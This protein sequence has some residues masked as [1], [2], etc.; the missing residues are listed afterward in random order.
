VGSG[1][2]LPSHSVSQMAAPLGR[3]MGLSA[4]EV[5]TVLPGLANFDAQ[6]LRFI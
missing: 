1:R 3:W 5:A 2:L 6:A 4:T